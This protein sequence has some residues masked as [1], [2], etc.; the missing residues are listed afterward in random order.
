M[1]RRVVVT[2]LGAITPVG[3]DVPTMWKNLVDGVC[4]IETITEFD[5]SHPNTIYG[6][7]AF[8]MEIKEIRIAKSPLV[9]KKAVVQ[10][11]VTSTSSTTEKT[12][13]RT[14]TVK[15]GDTL[16]ALAKKYYGA[17]AKYPTIYNADKDK[18]KNPD[19]IQIG[20]V[21]KIP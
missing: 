5:T 11:Q 8:S 9:V 10:K 18:I 17:G 2:G 16:W 15:R 20:W 3:N 12:T 6:G 7:C 14:H 13:E 1:S 19:L 4:G 21:L